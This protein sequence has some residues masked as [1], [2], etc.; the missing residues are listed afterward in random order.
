MSDK[1]SKIAVRGLTKSFKAAKERLELEAEAR[2]QAA[3]ESLR[4]ETLTAAAGAA[5]S[6]PS[7]DSNCITPG[8]PFM[9][10]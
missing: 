2:E 9:G 4:G 5:G 7:F 1:Q 10:K 6:A 8:T 3:K